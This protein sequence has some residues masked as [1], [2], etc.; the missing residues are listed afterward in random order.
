[1]PLREGDSVIFQGGGGGGY[2][3]PF[4]REPEAVLEDVRNEY[5]SLASAERDYGVVIDPS[6]WTVDL[7]ASARL[8]SG[9]R[10]EAEVTPVA[11]L[12]AT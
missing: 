8:R 10:P 1:M 6:S 2:G 5:V 4:E 11:E 9:E 7:E 3:D 12:T